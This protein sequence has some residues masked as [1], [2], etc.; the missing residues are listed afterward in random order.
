MSEPTC[1][2]KECL[3]FIDNGDGTFS[4]QVTLAS[5]GPGTGADT[6]ILQ[7]LQDDSGAT[8][9]VT[10]LIDPT[11]GLPSAAP[12][13]MDV[14]GAPYTPTG[15]IT[16]PKN[17]LDTEVKL[18][19]DAGNADQKFLKVIVFEED[20]T[21]SNVNDV[22]LLGAPYTPVGPIENCENE[23][24]P[25]CELVDIWLCDIEGIVEGVSEKEW[26]T[27]AIVT[28]FGEDESERVSASFRLTD[29]CGGLIHEN[30]PDDTRI[31]TAAVTTNIANGTSPDQHEIEFFLKL[32]EDTQLGIKVFGNSG[33]VAY[34]S[35]C[36]GKYAKIFDALRP[37]TLQGIPED[38]PI[39]IYPAGIYK[40]RILSS[41]PTSSGFGGLVWDQNNDGNYSVV[42]D[43]LF[44][45]PPKV[46][47]EKAWV[48]K[49]ENRFLALDG[50]EYL[51]TATTNIL[52]YDPCAAFN[53]YEVGGADFPP[54]CSL[55]KVYVI[56]TEGVNGA[57]EQY[58]ENAE[59]LD[60]GNTAIETA[61]TSVDSCG[62]IKHVNLPTSE[63]VITV[64]GA[65]STDPSTAAF[66]H[67]NRVEGYVII[68]R[69]GKYIQLSGSGLS[70]R[71]LYMAPC[72][73]K[74]QPV[75]SF[76]N[77]GSEEVGFYKA[78]VYHFVH[79]N[80]DDGTNGNTRLRWRNIGGTFVNIPLE[81]IYVD[82][83][84][85]TEHNA[86]VTKGDSA[87]VDVDG[88]EYNIRDE[89]I[90]LCDPCDNEI[91]VT[92]P[93]GSVG[94]GKALVVGTETI[95]IGGGDPL[96]ASLN[97]PAGANGA[98]VQVQLKDKVADA[99]NCIRYYNDGRDATA[100]RGFF[101]AHKEEIYLGCAASNEATITDPLS[102][103]EDFN[104][105]VG[106]T[107]AGAEFEVTY[108]A[109]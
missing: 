41:D 23:P 73:E 107:T 59:A 96:N 19:C 47:K 74:L 11:T 35:S 106:E 103:L 72:G 25:E 8:F 27:N 58:W 95:S 9:F 62:V 101:A 87:A 3:S 12:I 85:I 43:G 97:V 84:P 105:N 32:E 4:Q 13:Y 63:T 33:V 81:S 36:Y 90:F 89:N 38:N 53:I 22:D 34:A 44:T 48:K 102:E 39:G 55:E 2:D 21:I 92:N 79:F 91:P 76:S 80:H 68:P 82:A 99:S 88:V 94:S 51:E 93:I 75:T 65:R 69:P 56:N 7:C 29:G 46:T 14:T 37:V 77:S 30:D 31:K 26:T 49:G 57:T 16:K 71:A 1:R 40:F 70:A 28:P 66:P 61:F 109:F 64:D 50:T 52:C 60:P 42:N 108:Y 67:Q 45:Q 10:Y 100:T 17:P 6:P 83:P 24:E 104:V 15:T 98:I 20:G 54:E 78:G 86:W 5:P 18:F